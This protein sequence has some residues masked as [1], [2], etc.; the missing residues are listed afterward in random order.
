MLNADRPDGPLGQSQASK[1]STD[2]LVIGGGVMG[3]WAA[4]KAARLG[5]KVHLVEKDTIGCGASGG[6][7]GALMPYMPDKWDDKKQFQFRSLLALEDEIN[8]LEAMTGLSA[9]YRRSGRLIPFPKPHLRVIAERH[10]Q[11]AL[12]NWK[13]GDR[14]F[15]WRVEDHDVE[16]HGVSAQSCASGLVVDTLA[17]RVSPRA[18]IA[19]LRRALELNPQI[20]LSEYNG[21]RSID[22]HKSIATLQD[23]QTIA[24]GH[25]V[26]AAGYEAFPLLGAA[27]SKPSD[28][29]LGA[30]IKGQ[31]ALLRA[32]LDPA[33]PVVFLNGI[34][35]IPHEDGTVAIG[36]TSENS[37]ALPFAIDGQLDALL[38]RAFEV[39]PDLRS[40]DLI[41][42][43]AGL[44]PR[45]I[46]R[47]PM[48][49]AV[50][51]APNVIALAG[52]FKITFGLAHHLADAA[53]TF[54]TGDQPQVPDNFLLKHHLT[55]AE[56]S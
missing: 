20:T 17:A 16:R 6:L 8:A 13:D 33:S 15:Y 52:G 1:N 45:A 2:L 14:Q 54:V 9:G 22:A 43:W 32:K 38:E 40:G 39:M 26:I 34:Y 29:V 31:S 10:E 19:V 56:S 48:I 35:I 24:F 53:L 41:E 7:L 37:F 51:S 50:E 47:E 25:I 4:L 12:R 11:D 21:L 30:P 28:M 5:L 3:L 27:L 18:Y 44:R 36:S 42:R 46:G 49:G 23:G 55:L